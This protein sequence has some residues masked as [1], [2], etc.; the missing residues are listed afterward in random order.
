[1]ADHHFADVADAHGRAVPAPEHDLLDVFRTPR[2]AQTSDVIELAALGI[3]TSPGVAVIRGKRIEDLRDRQ[4]V[5][6]EPRRVEQHLI[7]H[8]RA[9][10]AGIVGDPGH[11]PV[12]ALQYPVF[13]GFELLRRAVRT[14]QHVTVNQAARAEE[15]RQL[16]RHSVRKAGSGQA[17]E[18][19]L[20]GK[21]AV[22]PLHE[23]DSNLREA[24]E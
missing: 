24:V 1:M 12:S 21:V 15:R 3:E 14:F 23:S 11:G 8:L 4:V 9:A 19:H 22:R 6:I 7:L 16:R 5:A 2:Q 10:E 17:L 13:K 18:N 20:P